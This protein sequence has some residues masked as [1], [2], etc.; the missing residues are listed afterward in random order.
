MKE[1]PSP[2]TWL[3][4]GGVAA[5]ILAALVCLL[6]PATCS[7]REAPPEVACE[8]RLDILGR[9]IKCYREKEGH[10]PRTTVGPTGI[11]CSWRA[12]I[13]R[14]LLED[15]PNGFDY[16]PDEPWD[17]PHNH[18][19]LANWVG[20]LLT[21][22]L[23]AKRADYQVVSYLMLERAGSKNATSDNDPMM[24]LPEDAV[25]VVESA[26][27]GIQYGEPKDIDMEDLFNGGSPFGPGR[28]NSL[29]PHVVKALRVDGKV[30]DISKD[31]SRED[32]RKLLQGMQP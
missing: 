27:C 5:A 3:I 28:L 29:H 10:L 7:V 30:I 9:A 24:L 23:E 26:K 14:Y 13:V 12:K 4:G 31:I 17:S 19:Q 1:N 2:A 32:L 22:P 11:K 21:C 8:G 6:F 25:L 15:V 18:P 16:R 20:G